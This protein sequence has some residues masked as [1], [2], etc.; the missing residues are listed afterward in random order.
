METSSCEP[1]QDWTPCE[2]YGHKFEEGYCRDCGEKQAD[3]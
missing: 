1:W 3:D 2:M